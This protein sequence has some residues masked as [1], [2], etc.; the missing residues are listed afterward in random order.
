MVITNIF[1]RGV[2]V[3]DLPQALQRPPGQQEQVLAPLAALVILLH[4]GYQLYRAEHSG[5]V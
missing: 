4:S 3:T 5:L 1:P 2:T